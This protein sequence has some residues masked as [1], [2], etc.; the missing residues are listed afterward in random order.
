MGFLGILGTPL[1]Y[2]MKWIYDMI[3]N[4]GWAIIIFTIVVRLASFPLQL[5]QQ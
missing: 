4:Y 5:Y 3:P 1:G 2:V